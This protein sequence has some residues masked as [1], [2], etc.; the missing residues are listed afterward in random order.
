MWSGRNLETLRRNVGIYTTS[1]TA[2]NWTKICIVITLGGASLQLNIYADVVEIDGDFSIS[3]YGTVCVGTWTVTLRE[4]C[5]HHLQNRPLFWHCTEDRDWKLLGKDSI[6]TLMKYAA[7][8]GRKIFRSVFTYTP[9]RTLAYP[10]KRRIFFK[11]L[12]KFRIS[13]NSVTAFW[14]LFAT[15]RFKSYRI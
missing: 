9:V 10:Q 2:F 8:W 11:L 14:S 3:G 1:H 12:R 6:C 5:C 4:P 7:D 13:H 15:W